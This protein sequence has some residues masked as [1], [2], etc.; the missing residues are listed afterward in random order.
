M[1]RST[2]TYDDYLEQIIQAQIDAGIVD[3]RSEFFR[4]AAYA[5][6]QVQL[7]AIEAAGFDSR[8][9]RQYED[10][11]IAGRMRALTG[12]TDIQEWLDR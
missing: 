12:A 4:E 5:I 1:A 10:E 7:T 11:E 3:S 2:I 8:D 6:L 9:L